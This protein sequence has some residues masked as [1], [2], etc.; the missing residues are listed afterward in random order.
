M[1]NVIRRL[2]HPV[3]GFVAGVLVWLGLAKLVGFGV[4]LPEML[5]LTVVAVAACIAVGGIGSSKRTVAEGDL[6]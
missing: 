6:A 2:T 1:S 3:R 5:A 4:G